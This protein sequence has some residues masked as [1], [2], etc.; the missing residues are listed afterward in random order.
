MAIGKKTRFGVA[1]AA[2]MVVTALLTAFSAKKVI[3]RNCKR[4]VKKE[5]GKV[6]LL[7]DAFVAEQADEICKV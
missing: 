1:I 7:S 5:L 2:T 6:P 4:Q 3:R